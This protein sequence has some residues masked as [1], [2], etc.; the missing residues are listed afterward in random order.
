MPPRKAPPA[1]PDTLDIGD[2]AVA[3]APEPAPDPD[4]EPAPDPAQVPAG[5]T[6]IRGDL[7]AAINEVMS[8]WGMN[9]RAPGRY[10]AQIDAAIEKVAGM[11]RPP[12]E[13]D[14]A[15]DR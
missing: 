1:G 2:E 6:L 12:M 4:P 10:T 7:I 8:F 14:D 11:L 15:G 5:Y 13:D 3:P 9:K